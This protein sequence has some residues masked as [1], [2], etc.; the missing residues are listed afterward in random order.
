MKT[1]SLGPLTVSVIGLGCNNFGRIGFPTE[2]LDG[3]RAVLHACIEHGV[4]FLDTAALYGGPKSV[5]E[6][7]MGEALRGRRD[8]VVIATKWGHT[9]GPEP[10]DWGA[11]GS[12]SFVKKACDASLARLQ[13]DR[14]DLFQLHEPDADTPIAETLGALDELRRA[15]K[16]VAYGHSNFD[17]DQIREAERVADE[18]GVARFVSAQN[19]YSLLARDIESAVIPACREAGIGLLPF[20]PLANG[21]LT[22]KYVRGE[23][24][25]AGSRLAHIAARFASVTPAQWDAVETYRAY[26]DELGVSMLHA[27]FAWLLAQ[28]VIPSVIAGATSPT[29]VEQNAAASEIE[30]SP[31]SVARIAEIFTL[32]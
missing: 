30:L 11:R 31:A 23:Q 20:F 18:L 16:I 14:I 25:P 26:C 27:T 9:A 8:Q 15:G 21:L 7:L 24:A 6:T 32:A 2:G 1:R 22:G 13:T 29:Q 28:D 12:A 17:A 10:A 4:T 19:H 3:T 5:S